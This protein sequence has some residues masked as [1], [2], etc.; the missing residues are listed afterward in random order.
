MQ[1]LTFYLIAF[2]VLI[3]VYE[4]NSSE[5]SNSITLYADAGS[6][7]YSIICNNSSDLTQDI[8]WIQTFNKSTFYY[9]KESSKYVLS[10][11]S[12]VLTITNV[13]LND[14]EYYACGYLIDKAFKIISTYLLYVRG[15]KLH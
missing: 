12:K 9:L 8:K 5:I 6:S 15:K 1:F 7:S 10:N 13:A 14:E 11:N 2:V 4:Y 3:Q